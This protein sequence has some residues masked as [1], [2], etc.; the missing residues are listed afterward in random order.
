MGHV[1]VSWQGK[2]LRSAWKYE[3]EE[4]GFANACWGLPGWVG[5]V[6]RSL[7]GRNHEAAAQTRWELLCLVS[8]WIWHVGKL[9]AAV[10]RPERAPFPLFPPPASSPSR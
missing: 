6:Y 9:A 10:G 8:L 7:W 2:D 3:G 5:Y 1:C 4:E